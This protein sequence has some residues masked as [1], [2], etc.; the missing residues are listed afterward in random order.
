M[1]RI[2]YW[3]GAV[4]GICEG[5]RWFALLGPHVNCVAP[6]RGVNFVWTP[7]MQRWKCCSTQ[8]QGS[9]EF[10]AAPEGATDFAG[11]GIAEAS[12]DTNL[13]SL[14]LLPSFARLPGRGRPGLRVPRA[15]DAPGRASLAGQPRAAVPT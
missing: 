15:L 2:S 1:F 10:S 8:N 5:L 13:A 4:N 9:A 11:Y 12:P 14:R 7:L 6:M 3:R